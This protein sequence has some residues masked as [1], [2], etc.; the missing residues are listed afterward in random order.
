MPAN[1]RDLRLP[2]ETGVAPVEQGEIGAGADADDDG[3]PLNTLVQ[4]GQ[5][6]VGRAGGGL[7]RLGPEIGL[8]VGVGPESVV[9][10]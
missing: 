5:R 9:A 8:R 3:P 6:R 2:Q 10:T 7:Y 1:Q 4:E